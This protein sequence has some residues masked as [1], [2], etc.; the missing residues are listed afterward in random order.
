[1][2]NQHLVSLGTLAAGVF[3]L[4][5]F[6]G[7]SMVAQTA[8]QAATPRAGGTPQAR[9]AAARAP[10]TPW[11]HPDLQGTWFVTEDVPLE[12]SAANAGREFLTDEE[13]AALDKRKAR[14]RRL[15]HRDRHRGRPEPAPGA[16]AA[17]ASRK[18][19]T[20]PNR[21]RRTRAVSA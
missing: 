21:S 6:T 11:G 3:G 2:R 18:R 15:E 10:R 14:W 5:A 13:V 17:A 16:P 8:P 12:R 4:V 1:M 19:M 9:A 7:S 20:I